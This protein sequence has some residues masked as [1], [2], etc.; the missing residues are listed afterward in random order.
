MYNYELK[1]LTGFLNTRTIISVVS[2]KKCHL[3]DYLISFGSRNI[4]VF[5]KTCTKI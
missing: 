1:I 4:N 3:I 2:Q 5:C